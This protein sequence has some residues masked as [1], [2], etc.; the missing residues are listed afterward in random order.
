MKNN[1]ALAKSPSSRLAGIPYIWVVVIVSALLMFVVNISTNTFG[2]F[3]K[4]I[5]SEFN[6]SRALIS[7]AYAFRSLIAAIFVIP[8]GYLADRYGPRWILLICFSL[9]G[10]SMMAMAIV[11]TVW[12]LY[13]VQ[14]FCVGIGISGPFICVTATVARWHDT[15]RGLALGIAT[16]GIG[17]SSLIF[18]PLATMLI[19][20]VDWQFSTFIMGV[21]ILVIAIPCSLL[22]KDPP[23]KR[24]EQRL[25]SGSISGS[26]FDAWRSLPIYL[27]NRRFFAIVMIFVLTGT[28]GF[29]LQ[30]H[31]INY[32]TDLGITA[33]VA[34]SM[35]SAS[36]IASTLGR[37]GIGFI[38]DIIG[39]K[40]DAA[41]CC[42]LL[43]LS[44]ILLITKVPALI[45][46]AAVLFGIGYGGS[47]PLIPALIVE[48]VEL[49]QLSSATGVANMG[50]FIGAAIGPWLGGLIFD[51]SGSYLWALILAAAASVAALVVVLGL[52]TTK[53]NIELNK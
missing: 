1:G 48:R 2:V 22:M 19:E 3:F 13:M 24:R 11:T 40:K 15:K 41:I 42:I 12:Q 28:V 5:A 43:A 29:M 9:L 14:G 37:L 20:A 52:S 4:P 26:A 25:S 32:A 8:L 53:L 39:A 27:K 17:V 16:A 46:V 36:G 38:S 23:Y 47:V 34:A 31:L 45:W 7:G 18:P 49:S 6:W 21:I 35:V 44:F 51:V 50:F 30:N 10:I 33:L